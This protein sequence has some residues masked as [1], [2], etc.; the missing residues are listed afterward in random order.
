MILGV[1]LQGDETLHPTFSR[2]PWRAPGKLLVCEG[3]REHS[4]MYPYRVF[5]LDDANAAIPELARLTS[6]VRERLGEVRR[7]YDE[8][9]PEAVRLLQNETRAI[10]SVWQQAVLEMGAEPKGIFTVD[11]RSPDPNVLWC[12]TIDEDEISHR[13]F[14]WESFKDRASLEVGG[15]AW[16]SSN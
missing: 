6:R 3:L 14:T 10:L 7:D 8:S 11:F 15:Q 9:D 12:W 16:P 13:H 4:T 2:S 1:C 5:T